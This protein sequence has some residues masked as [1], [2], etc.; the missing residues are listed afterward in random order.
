MTLAQ[1]IIEFR[2]END[3][4]QVEFA[5]LAR[6]NRA[7]LIRAENGGSVSKLTTAK[8]LYAISKGAKNNG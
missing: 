5:K 6:I 4:S 7:T 8:I 1:K 2:G 3:M